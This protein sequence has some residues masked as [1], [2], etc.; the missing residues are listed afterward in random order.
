MKALLSQF[1]RI[2]T[3]RCPKKLDGGLR[4][5]AF[6]EFATAREAKAAAEGCG[7]VHFYGRPLILEVGKEEDEIKD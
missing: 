5:F 2:V 7:G 6:A 3:L 4:G 1:G